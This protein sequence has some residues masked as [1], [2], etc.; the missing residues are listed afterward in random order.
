MDGGVVGQ[1]SEESCFIERVHGAGR[2]A[3]H[4]PALH[5][6]LARWRVAPADPSLPPSLT[7][8]DHDNGVCANE[9]V[10]RIVARDDHID[11]RCAGSD[12]IC[13]QT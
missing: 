13:C 7:D 8:G 3:V 10:P 5:L 2:A 9:L 11:L 12:F 4:R 1:R 6:H